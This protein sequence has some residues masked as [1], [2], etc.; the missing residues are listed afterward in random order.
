MTAT[1]TVEPTMTVTATP[2]AEQ[3]AAQTTSPPRN[4]VKHTA[5]YRLFW[6]DRR[7]SQTNFGVKFV[8]IVELMEGEK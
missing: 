8:I 7:Q 2:T 6:S 1:V 4:A 3:E 5:Q